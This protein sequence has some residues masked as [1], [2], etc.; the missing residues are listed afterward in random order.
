MREGEKQLYKAI[1]SKESVDNE[2][3]EY[4][5]KVFATKIA[6]TSLPSQ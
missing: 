6:P 5:K 2:Y 1:L 4:F 3:I